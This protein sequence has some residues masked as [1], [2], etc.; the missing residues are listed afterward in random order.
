MTLP[1]LERVSTRG[2]REWLNL[3]DR[4]WTPAPYHLYFFLLHLLGL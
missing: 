2:W 3:A 4:R 1:P